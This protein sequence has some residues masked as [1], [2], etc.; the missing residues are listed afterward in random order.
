MATYKILGA[1]RKEYGP[2]GPEEIRRWLAEGRLNKDSMA[3]AEGAQ[4]WKPLSAFAEFADALQAQAAQTGQPPIQGSAPAQAISAAEILARPSQVMIG[5]C[6]TRSWKLVM[7]NA[8]VLFGSTLLIWLISCA[9]QFIPFG[10]VIYFLLSGVFYG[11]LYLV[12][13]KRI[14]GQSATVADAFGGFSIA[15]AQLLLVGII[16]KLLSIIGLVCC[17][18][19]PGIYLIV[20]WVFGMPL[21]IDKGL[22]FW[23]AMELS[24]KMVT[25]VWFEILA[26]LLV[27]FL[28][29]I[30]MN[31]VVQVKISSALSPILQD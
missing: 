11:G 15:F 5:S 2:V 13:L 28:P 27:A 19:L 9:C 7:E 29:V 22:E 25:R 10:S 16:S 1:D 6:L 8:G 31:I 24:R 30:V 12:F 21:V 4:E 17:L 26:L 14:R 18:I 23:A 20:A 3:I